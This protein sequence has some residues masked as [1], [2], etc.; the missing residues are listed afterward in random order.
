M[1]K[2]S[3]YL[4]WHNMRHNVL[5]VPLNIHSFIHSLCSKRNWA[6]GN[7]FNSDL[8]KSVVS[9]ESVS[10]VAKPFWA[11]CPRCLLIAQM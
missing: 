2:F 11:R 3:I 7:F 4:S 1:N 8:I 6:S 5:N 10:F 9:F